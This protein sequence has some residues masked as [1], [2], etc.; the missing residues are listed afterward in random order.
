MKRFLNVLLI[1]AIILTWSVAL[2]SCAALFG[3]N[4]CASHTDMNS[5]GIC[6]VCGNEYV[7][8][9]HRDANSDS[10]CDFCFA[11][12]FCEEHYDTDANLKCDYCGV[13]YVCPGHA[14]V[15]S[16]STCDVCGAHFSCNKHTDIDVNGKCDVCK[17]EF[18]CPSHVD[19][20]GDKK[21]DTCLTLWS[22]PGHKDADGNSEC[23]VCGASWVCPGHADAG[24]DGYCDNCAVVWSCPG[25]K[26]DSP[27][28]GKCDVC[29]KSYSKPVDYRDAFIAAA[30]AT[31]PAKL[32]VTVKT[33]DTELG[34]LTSV[35]EIVFAED[36]SFTITGT[37]QKFNESVEGDLVITETVYIT[38]DADGNY[39]DGADFAGSNLAATGLSV[40]FALLKNFSTPTANVLNA[41]VASGDTAAVFG[42]DLGAQVSLVVNK[43][44]TAITVVSVSYGNVNINCSYQ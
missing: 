42:V 23:D 39:S 34:T 4:R 11:Y 41:T 14:D 17:A 30:A 24:A 27:E 9:G 18:V 12:F 31:N 40:N 26:D 29:L 2:S 32:T 38:C 8:P 7:C 43:N 33:N 44:A 15:N 28:D 16:D 37:V 21:C 36:G 22:C 3:S 20:N 1:F 6:D 19:K 10:Y 25:H 5:D 35:Y 13:S